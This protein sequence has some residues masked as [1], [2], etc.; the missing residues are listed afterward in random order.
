MKILAMLL[1]DVDNSRIVNENTQTT[2]HSFLHLDKD[3]PDYNAAMQEL[4]IIKKSN[5]DLYRKITM[6]N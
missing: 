2:L 3:H 1:D 5:P 4:Q 6:L